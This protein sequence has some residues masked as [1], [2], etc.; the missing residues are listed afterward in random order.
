VLSNASPVDFLATRDDK[1]V[2]GEVGGIATFEY[3]TK[4]FRG[5][6]ARKRV[7]GG[8]FFVAFGGWGLAETE[9][10]LLRDMSLFRSLPVDLYVN[11]GLRVDTDLGR[12]EFSFAN[13]LGR[14]R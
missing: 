4:L 11:T 12:F 14:L 9:D 6:G 7:Y 5:V 1:P 10:Y 13:A 3:V 8:D 2:Y